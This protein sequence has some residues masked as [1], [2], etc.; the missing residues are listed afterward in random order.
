MYYTVKVVSNAPANR[1]LS[2]RSKLLSATINGVSQYGADQLAVSHIVEAAGVSRPTFYSHFGD[3]DGVLA[4]I[5]VEHGEAWALSMCDPSTTVR[6]GDAHSRALLEIFLVAHRKPVI[7]ETLAARLPSLLDNRFPDVADRTIALWTF[8]NRLGICAT[9]GVWDA[10]ARA[11]ILDSYLESV[12]GKISNLAPLE[13]EELTAISDTSEQ[14]IESELLLGAL[15]VVQNSGVHALTVSRLARVLGVTS[16]YVYPRIT[17]K[18]HLVAEAFDH[19]LTRATTTNVARWQQKKLGIEGFAEYI[20]GGL[21]NSRTNWRRFRGE[22]LLA[23]PHIPELREGV[24][25]ALDAFSER[26]MKP[27]SVLPVPSE[28]KRDLA[29]LVHTILFGFSA[30]QA[31]DIAVKNLAH[32]GIIQAMLRELGKR[33][34]RGTAIT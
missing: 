17:G 26:V 18:G 5:W 4:E 13:T 23:A 27:I 28:L 9:S 34:L 10:A 20:V 32:V 6:H 25:V 21:S 30:L 24:P 14:G 16:A 11:T 8:A 29:A 15:T 12:R 3:I 19:A 22:V 33:V 1:S 31:A 7:L 2:S